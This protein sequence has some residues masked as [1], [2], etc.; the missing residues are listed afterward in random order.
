[1]S[2]DQEQKISL[3]VPTGLVAAALAIGLSLAAYALSSKSRE[4]SRRQA[5]MRKNPV[6]GI[7]RRLGLRTF[8][9]LLENDASR[10]FLTAIVGRQRRLRTL[11]I[12]IENNVT[13][14]ILITALK[15]ISRRM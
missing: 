7:A 2:D 15:G 14:R 1:M 8:I 6:K 4:S 9:V 10:V 3:S 5:A 12:L 13:R 11:K